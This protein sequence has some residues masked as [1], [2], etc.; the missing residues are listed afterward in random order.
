MQMQGM[1][2]LNGKKKHICIRSDI[3]GICSVNVVD[4]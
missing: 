3:Y 2:I 1:E 4:L